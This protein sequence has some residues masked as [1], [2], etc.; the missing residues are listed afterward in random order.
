MKVKP[1]LNPLQG[2]HVIGVDPP[3]KPSFEADWRRRLNLYTGRSLSD[4]ALAVEQDGRTGRLATRGQMVSP[5]GVSGLEIELEKVAHTPNDN[6]SRTEIFFYKINSGFGI[7]RS[8]EDVI[9]PR[10]LEIDVANTRVYAPTRVVE[11]DKASDEEQPAPSLFSGKLLE[12]RLLGPP[13]GEL[14]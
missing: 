8:G 14:S 6:E 5:G 4:T 13:L 10:R 1:I 3:L 2:E 7:A 9:V 12:G 11:P